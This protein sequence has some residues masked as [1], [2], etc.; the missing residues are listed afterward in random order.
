MK[1]HYLL[2]SI[3]SL[4]LITN[5]LNAQTTD[6]VA[7][8]S[9]PD[10]LLLNGN[11]LYIAESGWDNISKIDITAPTPTPIDVVTGLN[12]VT[13]LLLIEND[14]YFTV[15]DR[16]TKIDIT[17]LT[18]TPIDVVTGLG[19]PTRLVSYGSYIYIA[20]YSSGRISRINLADETPI[21]E[22]VVAVS[23]PWGLLLSG[24]DLYIAELDAG[25]ISKIDITASIPTTATDVITGLSKP[26]GLALKGNDL[27]ISEYGAGKIV[28]IDITA[29]SPTTTEVVTDLNLPAGIVINGN[30]LYISEFD[31]IS[32]FVISV[33]GIEELS[34]VEGVLYPNPTTESI[35][36]SNLKDLQNFKIYNIQGALM[37]EGEVTGDERINVQNLT[38]GTYFM[39]LNDLKVVK[40]LKN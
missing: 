28:K 13:G 3:V 8:L 10:G 5:Y 15:I 37:L 33:L 22:L 32:K 31:R 4:F 12:Y 21:P 36:F 9:T 11:D 38:T 30:D 25:K 16:V 2:I 34:A 19:G 27:Y 23:G 1:K 26:D 35:Q 20:E 7:G 14:L 24:T 40:F 29:P 39:V 17:D 18:P 6:V